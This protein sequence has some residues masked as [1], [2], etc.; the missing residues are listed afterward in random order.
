MAAWH[1]FGTAWHSSGT[2]CK[3]LAQFGTAWHHLTTGDGALTY[4]PSRARTSFR[5]RHC[6]VWRR[7]S[8]PSI[9]SVLL[10]DHKPRADRPPGT[11][12]GPS[13]DPAWTDSRTAGQ[14]DRQTDRQTDAALPESQQKKKEE[15][16]AAA[17]AAPERLSFPALK[18]E[19]KCMAC[20]RGNPFGAPHI[21]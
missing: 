5:G 9:P 20:P 12:P 8:I 15:E 6:S 2:A 7:D 16:A 10:D 11:Q 4:L 3:G 13:L 21:C 19:A 14:P 18:L 1:S 17:S